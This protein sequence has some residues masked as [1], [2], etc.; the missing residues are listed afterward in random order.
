MGKISKIIL[1]VIAAACI[2][3]LYAYKASQAHE[4]DLNR[5]VQE[6]Q[7]IESSKKIDEINEKK[8]QEEKLQQELKDNADNAEYQVNRWHHNYYVL[9]RKLVESSMLTTVQVSR[10]KKDLKEAKEQ[11]LY[12]IDK[13]TEELREKRANAEA[14]G[15]TAAVDQYN[16][17]LEEVKSKADIIEEGDEDFD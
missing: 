2:I 7:R 10:L 9:K 5:Q 4:R 1:Y 12:W 13:R 8:K 6:Y 14:E 16:R 11:L 17:E 15:N 3:G